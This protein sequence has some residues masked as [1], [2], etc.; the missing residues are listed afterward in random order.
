MF[1][2]YLVGR[3]YTSFMENFE[4]FGLMSVEEYLEFER[5]SE[6]RHEY[7]GGVTYA[8]TGASRRHNRIAVNIL[9]KLA[10]AAEGGPCRTFISDMK[11]LTPDDLFYYPDV[12]VACGEEPEDEYYEDEPC[13]IVEVVSPNTESKD[14]R[15]K[16]VA[17]RKI[18]T[19]EAYL[20]VDQK[21]RHVERYFRDRNGEWNRAELTGEGS[22]PVPCPPGAELSLAE[23]YEGL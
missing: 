10:D 17:Y 5:D 23:I 3:G 1:V 4:R 18:P 7:V 15:E 9:R 6:V 16:L 22:L 11:V 2:S 12:V 14:R 8:M 19:L 20:I 13:L 21:R